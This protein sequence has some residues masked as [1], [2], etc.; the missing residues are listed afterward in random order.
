MR[1][2]SSKRAAPSTELLWVVV[3]S[4][5]VAECAMT[6]VAVPNWTKFTPSVEYDAMN[7]SPIAA[8]S[9]SVARRR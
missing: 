6:T 5:A 2:T 8:A 9:A 3:A 7:V 1:R 4:P